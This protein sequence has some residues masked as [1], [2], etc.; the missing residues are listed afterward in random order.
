[1]VEP[2]PQSVLFCC[3]HNAVRSP[4]AEGIMKRFYGTGTYVQSAG[5]QNDMEIDGFSISVC[6]EI[7]VELSR[8][9]SRSFEEM[10]PRGDDLSSFDVIVALSPHSHHRAQE[11]TRGFSTEVVYW[12]IP[13]PSGR[14]EGREARL[15]AY[16]GVRD[17]IVRHLTE[18]WGPSRA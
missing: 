2:L 6:A 17:E 5:V 1:M 16:R 7:G 11:L 10:G 8:H 14:C 15:S 3:D 12:P 9:R 13:D 18:R 4:M